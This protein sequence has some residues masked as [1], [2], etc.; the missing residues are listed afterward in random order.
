MRRILFTQLTHTDLASLVDIEDHRIRVEP[1]DDLAHGE[2]TETEKRIIDHV[3]AGLRRVTPSL[4][5]EATV[6]SRAIYPLLSLAE[7]EDSVAQA[8]V[9]LVGRIGDVELAGS[10]DGALGTPASGDLDAPFLVV[11]EAKRGVEGSNPVVQ[12][13]GEMLAAACLN[14]KA[15][16]QTAL[17]IY[18]CFTVADDWTF[19]RAD[20]TRARHG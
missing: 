4:V 3:L 2:L 6:W 18:G 12:L 15:G 19:V 7:T 1:W 20:V 8:D 11:V 16:K 9:P 5:N 14:A 13:Y 10:A 17:R